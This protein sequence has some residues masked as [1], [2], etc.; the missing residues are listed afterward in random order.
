MP[1]AWVSEA[2]SSPSSSPHATALPIAPTAPGGWNTSFPGSNWPELSRRRSC[3][4]TPIASACI[5]RRP[6]GTGEAGRPASASARIAGSTVD[7]EW[8]AGFHIGSKSS[9][10]MAA[11]LTRAA[12]AG[13]TRRRSPI[14]VAD[15][16][17]AGVVASPARMRGPVSPAPSAATAKPSSA[18]VRAALAAAGSSPARWRPASVAAKAAVRLIPPRP[19]GLW[20]PP[21]CGRARRPRTSAAASGRGRHG[22]PWPVPDPRHARPRRRPR[23]CRTDAPR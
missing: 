4:S 15:G 14:S 12:S 22:R 5:S 10:C 13:V 17:S 18:R 9:T 20:W 6:S 7:S 1:I 23:W 3:A 11:P 19:A 21:G 8:L 2:G 16:P